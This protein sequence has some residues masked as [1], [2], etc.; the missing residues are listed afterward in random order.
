MLNT[1]DLDEIFGHS[2]EPKRVVESYTQKY[3]HKVLVNCLV[4]HAKVKE[5][6]VR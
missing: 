4:K 3:V 2:A 1:F 5:S 6:V